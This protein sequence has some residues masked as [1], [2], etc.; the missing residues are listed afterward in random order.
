MIIKLQSICSAE[1]DTDQLRKDLAHHDYAEMTDGEILRHCVDGDGQ[2]LA[3]VATV[4]W[5]HESYSV[6]GVEGPERAITETLPPHLIDL[7]KQTLPPVRIKYQGDDDEAAMAGRVSG[8][9]NELATVCFGPDETDST[10]C[11]D[12]GWETVA[13]AWFFDFPL[14]YR[15]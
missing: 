9:T 1:I 3:L 10:G 11:D 4:Y 6:V 13:W 7:V 2:W 5:Q 15:G 8:R 14:V 12:Y